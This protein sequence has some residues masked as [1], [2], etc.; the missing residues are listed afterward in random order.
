MAKKVLLWLLAAFITLAAVV[1]QRMTGPTYPKR[2]KV[3]LNNQE[4]KLRLLR[5]HG[6]ITDAPIELAIAADINASLHYKYYP[7]HEGEEW[8]EVVFEKEGEKYVAKL[9]NQPPAG[10]L[11]YYITITAGEKIVE[12][13]KSNPVVIRFKGDVPQ[14]VLVPHVILMFL[15]ML[16]ANVSGL[17]ALGKVESFRRYTFVTFAFLTIGGM[18]LGP[19]VQKYAFGELWT[20][21]PF[22][23]DL[24]DNKTLIAFIFWLVAVLGQLKKPRPYLTIIASVIILVVYSIPHSMFGSELDRSTGVVTQGFIHFMQFFNLN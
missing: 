10:K 11:M 23:W 13:E 5:S 3:E 21:V 22:G 15:A 20:G 16:L 8:K 6:G 18:I 4:Y 2:V 17:F 12:L 7:V 9:P 1:Y 24:T 19:V 14:A